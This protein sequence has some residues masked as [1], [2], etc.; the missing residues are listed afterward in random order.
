MLGGRTSAQLASNVSSDDVIRHII[1]E[2]IARCT[3]AA[4]ADAGADHP[5][6]SPSG[7]PEG[8]RHSDAV[9]EPTFLITET[10]AAFMVRAIV[11][12]PSLGFKV[13]KELSKAEVERL[14]QVR[15]AP[16]TSSRAFS[17]ESEA[18]A[19]HIHSSNPTDSHA[20][21]ELGLCRTAWTAC[22]DQ[23]IPSSRPSSCKSSLTQTSRRKVSPPRPSA[24]FTFQAIN[25]NRH[26]AFALR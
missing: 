11:V 17:S 25:L 24:C 15:K 23:M 16:P 1:K 12:D 8:H 21:H 18:V 19:A 4:A 7:S 13:D 10:L 6:G 20:C 5:P 14:V 22:C 3:P 2:I 9:R 26:I